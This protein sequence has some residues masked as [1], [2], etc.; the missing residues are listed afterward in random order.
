MDYMTVAE[1]ADAL[2]VR[3]RTIIIYVSRGDVEGAEVK[4][5]AHSHRWRWYIPAS[6]VEQLKNRYKGRKGERRANGQ[7]PVSG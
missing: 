7:K 1:V 3:R 4:Y 5:D 2:Q 6:A